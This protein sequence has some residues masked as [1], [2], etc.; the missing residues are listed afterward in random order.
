MN[1][2]SAKLNKALWTALGVSEGGTGD[3]RYTLNKECAANT[4]S[5][6]FQSG[7]G[8]RAEFGL[9]G[10][11]DVVLKI[12]P[13]G[14]AWTEA[15]RV[16]PDGK[17]GLGTSSPP[18]RLSVAGNIAPATDNTH[19]LGTATRRFSAVYAT[20]GTVSTSDI[21]AK[22]D[23]EP[24]DAELALALLR[25]ARPIAFAW[26]DGEPGRHFGWSAQ[27]WLAALGTREA[28]CGPAVRLSPDRPDGELGLR[29]D[30]VTA[31][32]HAAL[33]GLADEL[34]ALKERLARLEAAT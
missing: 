25:R 10:N 34:A 21:R 22:R 3:L 26:R 27:D 15:L 18:E 19:S 33:L 24:V 11:D 8:G 29:A 20:T 13:D 30:Q 12:S 1:P 7:Y 16:K 4:L 14:S 5:L 31:I 2:F 9:I 32:V 17:V 23:I 28:P 6:L